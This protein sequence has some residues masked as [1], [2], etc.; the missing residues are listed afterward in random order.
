MTNGTSASIITQLWVIFR[1]SD[2]HYYALPYR[3]SVRVFPPNFF[4]FTSS[5]LKG[6][7]FFVLPTHCYE[8]FA[9]LLQKLQ[10]LVLYLH[11]Q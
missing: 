10:S 3:N 1:Y 2:Y 9:K 8:Y 7:F 4:S 11:T 5:L 6:V